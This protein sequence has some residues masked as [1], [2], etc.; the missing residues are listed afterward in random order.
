MSGVCE[1]HLYIYQ[2]VV[3]KSGLTGCLT[4]RQWNMH[5]VCSDSVQ[6]SL[7]GS[8]ALLPRC[9]TECRLS[10]SEEPWQARVSIRFSV[11]KYGSPLD[12][13]TIRPFGDTIF[14]NTH[15]SKLDIEDRIKRAQ[16]AVLNP[17]IPAND[18]LTVDLPF[19]KPNESRFSKNSIILDIS[20]PTV[21]DLAFVDLPGL[22]P[23]TLPWHKTNCIFRCYCFWGR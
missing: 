1:A 6:G 11:D 4:S 17:G 23:A 10:F 3:L 22:H 15:T 12:K 7:S 9:P 19:S 18:F 5:T 13:T 2:C 16:L 14:E 20:G 8:Q 21:N